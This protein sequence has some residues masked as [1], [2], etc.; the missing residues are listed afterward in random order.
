MPTCTQPGATPA[1]AETS[2]S[3]R[4]SGSRKFALGYNKLA[5]GNQQERKGEVDRLRVLTNP[6]SSPPPILPRCIYPH[7][8]GHFS[9]HTKGEGKAQRCTRPPGS[10]PVIPSPPVPAADDPQGPRPSNPRSLS[11]SRPAEKTRQGWQHAMLCCPPPDGKAGK[12]AGR[13]VWF[14]LVAFRP[15]LLGVCSRILP[16]CP[17]PPGAPQ[18]L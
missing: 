17:P 7:L 15:L 4:L 14:R 12:K 18:R 8:G 11:L 9:R 16:A 2:S 1:G 5:Q 13:F 3:C 6:I 10:C